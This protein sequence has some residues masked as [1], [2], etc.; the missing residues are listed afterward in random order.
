MIEPQKA[1]ESVTQDTQC[2]TTIYLWFVYNLHILRQR[3]IVNDSVEA[4]YSSM[5]WT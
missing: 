5:C 1:S 2:T 4:E 3:S